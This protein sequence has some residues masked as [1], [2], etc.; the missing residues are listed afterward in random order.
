LA[1]QLC[2]VCNKSVRGDF[3]SFYFFCHSRATC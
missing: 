2:I 1:D 3:V